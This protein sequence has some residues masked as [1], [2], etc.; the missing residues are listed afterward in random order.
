MS[1]KDYIRANPEATDEQIVAHGNAYTIQYAETWITERTLVGKFGLSVMEVAALVFQL[2]RLDS[3]AAD[4]A[5]YAKKAT[6]D[7]T[8]RLTGMVL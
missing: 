3:G 1:L 8:L 7:T 4:Y 2:Y 5:V 6:D